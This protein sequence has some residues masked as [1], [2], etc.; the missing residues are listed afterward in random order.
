MAF[1]L[2]KLD[3]DRGTRVLAALIADPL[4]Q[5]YR[6]ECEELLTRVDQRRCAAAMA[7]LITNSEAQLSDRAATVE[8]LIE[9]DEGIARSHWRSV[10]KGMPAHSQGLVTA[11]V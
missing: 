1:E 4:M 7:E 3:R 9:I 5:S 2:L 6:I 10:G 11:V 8:R